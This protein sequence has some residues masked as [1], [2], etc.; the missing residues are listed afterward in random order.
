MHASHKNGSRDSDNTP[1]NPGC[2]GKFGITGSSYLLGS[3]LGDR[4]AQTSVKKVFS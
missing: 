4:R 3:S 1:C 2:G